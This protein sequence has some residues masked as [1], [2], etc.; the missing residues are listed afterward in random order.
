V[1]SIDKI[2]I[3]AGKPGPVSMLMQTQYLDIVHGRVDDTHG[4]LTHCRD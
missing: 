2:T 4:W 3:G 1:R